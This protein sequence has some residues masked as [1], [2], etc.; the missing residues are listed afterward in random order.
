MAIDPNTP[1]RW[2]KVGGGALRLRNRIIKPGQ[3]FYATPA[4]I[5]KSFR[6]VVKPLDGVNPDDPKPNE[7]IK[8]EAVK[9]EYQVVPRGD[10]TAWFDVIGPGGK[11]I[12]TKA[13]RKD[14]AEKFAQDLAK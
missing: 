10:S 2:K 14:I 6:D 8:V 9:V 4:E 12:N 7:P 3:V 1:I 13:L 11:A 5:S